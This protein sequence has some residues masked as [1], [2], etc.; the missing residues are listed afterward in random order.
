MGP[1]EV[2]RRQ[3]SE[4]LSFSVPPAPAVQ[5]TERSRAD[6]YERHT[7]R[8]RVSDGDPVDAFFL[9]PQGEGPFAAVVA[10]HQHNSQWHL[11]KSE[12]IGLAG[13]PL[14]AFG[15]ALAAR[16]VAVLAADQVG[17]EDRR[18][19]AR[20]TEVGPNDW[21]EYFNAMAYRLLRG[22]LLMA[23]VLAD[24][25]V[26]LSVLA[27]RD[28]VDASR[29]GAVGHSMGGNTVLFHAALD[30]RIH[31]A[32]ASGAAC[33]FRTRMQH[34]TG[35]EMAS[36]IPGLTHLCDI[37]DLVR[38]GP[39]RMLLVSGEGDEFARDAGAVADAAGV[40]HALHGRGHAL[41]AERF[42]VISDWLID[43]A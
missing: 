6:G 34:Q 13:E 23:K 21:L 40:E 8:Y 38:L 24:A 16:G 41:D 36:V 42:R 7:L 14:Q 4:R 31:F 12:V 22:Q 29:I 5:T 27:A 20:G 37:D 9:R 17:F 1:P 10:Y 11:G 33:T 30:R 35:I 26:A 25:S 32:C 19:G 15:P 2:L 43:A 18:L 3:L 28:D 39:R